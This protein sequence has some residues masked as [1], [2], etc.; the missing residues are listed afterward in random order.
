VTSKRVY[1]FLV[2]EVVQRV[3]DS[4]TDTIRIE[5]IDHVGSITFTRPDRRNALH[6]DMYEPMIRAI[7]SFAADPEVG[8]VV[9]TGE[10]S[11]FCAGGDVREGSGR[12]R[13]DGSKPSDEERAAFLAGNAR[14]CVL[15]REAPIITMA[16]VNGPAVGAG[17]AIAL[18]CDLR[19]AASSAR[20]IGG[21][22][23][24]AF[25]GDFGGAWLLAQRVGESR[26]VEMLATNRTVTAEEAL[27]LRMVDRV[28]AD[29]E[30]HAAWREWAAVFAR[31]PKFALGLMK[32]NVLDSGRLS[33]ADAISVESARQV[34]SGATADH[35]EAV[36]AWVERRD[37]NFRP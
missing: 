25:S 12:R 10:G 20:F 2:S 33:L 19:I 9:V 23:R 29:E 13:E 36:R 30:F 7:E 16:A 4:N 26:A 14:V 24:L 22:A 28:V 32:Q 5:V 3:I 34:A 17:M 1:D 31:G 18:A 15:L 8:C 27:G 6:D 35:R 37:P 11:A 21:W